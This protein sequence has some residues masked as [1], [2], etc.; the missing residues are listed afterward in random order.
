MRCG[1]WLLANGVSAPPLSFGTSF[2]A[3]YFPGVYSYFLENIKV[4]TCFSE[5]IAQHWLN[6]SVLSSCGAS[7]LED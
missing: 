7:S 2:V 4:G 3:L 1:E 6:F 5:G